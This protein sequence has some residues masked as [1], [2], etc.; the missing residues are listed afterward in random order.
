MSLVRC[1]G[2]VSG[3]VPQAYQHSGLDGFIT[4]LMFFTTSTMVITTPGAVIAFTG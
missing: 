2:I 3:M 1:M 4:T